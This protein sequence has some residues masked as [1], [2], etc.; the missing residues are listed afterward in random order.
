MR[1][2]KSARKEL[3]AGRDPKL[4]LT[5]KKPTLD[6]PSVA[7]EWL[8]RDQAKHRTAKESKRIIDIYVLPH[9]SGRQI[10]EI[11]RRDVRDLIDD[12][13][14][15]GTTTQATLD[16]IVS[17]DGPLAAT[18]SRRVPWRICR[19]PRPTW[20]LHDLRRSVATG[21]QKLGIPLQ[22][23][24]SVLGHV[25]GSRAG[26]I[27]IYQ[28]HDYAYEKRAALAAW[29]RY[30]S[31]LLDEPV[32]QAITAELEAGEEDAK[33]KARLAFNRAITEGNGSWK[34]YVDSIMSADRKVLSMVGRQ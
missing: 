25:S 28:R 21:L 1:L 32:H 26:V 23:T 12:I 3:A 31:M 34:T 7:E 24:E 13:V 9:W 14:D 17:F 5:Q 16:S 19:R 29:G 27:G 15:R 22:V 33:I 10:N 2:W 18:S 6:F 4:S 8:K 11:E 30:V 20:R